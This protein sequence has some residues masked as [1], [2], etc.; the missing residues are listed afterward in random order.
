MG[1]LS[2]KNAE[3]VVDRRWCRRRQQL[4][5]TNTTNM[6]ARYSIGCEYPSELGASISQWAV[7][8]RAATTT[9]AAANT[10]SLHP[11]FLSDSFVGIIFFFSILSLFIFCVFSNI[12]FSVRFHCHGSI[13]RVSVWL[14][15][16]ACYRSNACTCTC[17]TNEHCQYCLRDVGVQQIGIPQTMAKTCYLFSLHIDANETDNHCHICIQIYPKCNAC[18]HPL[19][20]CISVGFCFAC[21]VINKRIYTIHVEFSRHA[22]IHSGAHHS[23][24]NANETWG[25]KKANKIKTPA[26]NNKQMIKFNCTPLIYNLVHAASREAH[27]HCASIESCCS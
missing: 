12:A 7:S 1:Q 8:A 20:V 11:I 27:N 13:R 16:I 4:A 25:E 15:D 23:Q 19:S 6:H 2:N 9:I 24:C 18:I 14:N 22:N 21:S 10:R 5:A 17:Y 26:S 3:R